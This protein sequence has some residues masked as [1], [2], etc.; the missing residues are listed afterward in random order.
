MDE[1]CRNCRQPATHWRRYEMPHGDVVHEFYFPWCED[2]AASSRS[3][4]AAPRVP[5]AEVMREEKSTR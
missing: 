2:C 1:K 5:L 3:A 4:K